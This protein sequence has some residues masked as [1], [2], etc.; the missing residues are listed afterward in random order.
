MWS[1]NDAELPMNFE[2]RDIAWQFRLIRWKATLEGIIL[3]PSVSK[4][5]KKSKEFN[6][7]SKVVELHFKKVQ[8]TLYNGDKARA[9]TAW[10]ETNIET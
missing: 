6:E 4:W 2:N 3:I 10:D 8:N 7:T 1:G 5:E 9:T